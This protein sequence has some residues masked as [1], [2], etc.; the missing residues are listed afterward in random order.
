[1]STLFNPLFATLVGLLKNRALLHL[2]ILALRQQLAMVAHRDQKRMCFSRQERLFWVLLYRNWP[3]CLQTL[4]VFKPDT[5]VRWHRKGFRI[6]WRW[7][8]IHGR[9]GRLRV[10]EE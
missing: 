8:S 4:M 10:K 7:I 6:Y 1:V 3:D 2:D 5:L 9:G